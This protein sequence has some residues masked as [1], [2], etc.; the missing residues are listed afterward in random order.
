MSSIR[1][2]RRV[3][4]LS[5][6]WYTHPAWYDILHASGT[7]EEVKGL[8][9][10]AELFTAVRRSARDQ[11][12][13]LEPGCGTARYLR[14]AAATGIRVAGFDNCAPMLDYARTGFRHRG[15]TGDIFDATFED[16]SLSAKA[17]FAF[18]LI[19]TIRHLHTDARV[20]AHFGCMARALRKGGAYAVGLSV[21]HP[22]G[23]MDTED[24][25]CGARGSCAVTQLINY[26]SPDLRARTERVASHIRVDTPTREIHLDSSYTLRTYTLKQWTSLIERSP[27]RLIAVVDEQG[28][29]LLE[30]SPEHDGE[31]GGWGGRNL[32]SEYAIWV[33][34]RR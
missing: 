13:W 9:R 26:L 32:R 21:V 18:C 28:D 17:D 23:E 5:E 12:L 29:G 3:E 7:A 19:N 22:G 33:L 16:F 11:P 4:H 24:T 6:D 15:L 14:A 20:L 30:P 27:L 10:I 2:K 34:G 8:T 1:A 31:C 25:W